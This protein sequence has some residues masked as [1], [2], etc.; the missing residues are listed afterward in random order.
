MG[1][2]ASV[3]TIIGAKTKESHQGVVWAHYTFW[4]Q[5]RPS[6]AGHRGRVLVAF[7]AMDGTCFD[8]S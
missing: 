4:S 6:T 8:K 1:G 5:G 3:R 2:W 7:R